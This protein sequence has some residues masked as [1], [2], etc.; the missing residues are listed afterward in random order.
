MGTSAQPEYAAFEEKVKHTVY[1][2]NL[3]PRVSESVLRNALEQFG[4][5][6]SIQFIPNYLGPRNMPRCAL[7]EMENT[8]QANSVLSIL[9]QFPFMIN[10]MPR[11]VT[12]RPA[13]VEMFSDPPKKPGRNI[14]VRWLDTK[15]PDFAVV[16]QLKRLA[17]RHSA[18]AAFMLEKQ[19]E[20]E[21]KLALQQQNTLKSNYKKY[22]MIDSVFAD[23]AAR[24]L[25]RIY[26]MNVLDD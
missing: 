18:E 16:M 24:R 6:K 22:E 21:E 9:A 11:P 8:K 23:G 13:E 26:N 25:A 1:M 10:G 5:V 19:L 20:E 7:V 3:S 4:S 14:T 17:Q 12:A 15:D 2:D